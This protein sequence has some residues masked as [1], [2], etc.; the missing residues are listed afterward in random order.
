MRPRNYFPRFQAPL[1]AIFKS[2]HN[3]HYKDRWLTGLGR[4]RQQFWW[5]A[6]HR[7]IAAVWG[8]IGAFAVKELLESLLR[9][10]FSPVSRSF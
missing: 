6:F 3:K 7:R 1:S 10:G 2:L 5:K 4:T 8:N 9:A